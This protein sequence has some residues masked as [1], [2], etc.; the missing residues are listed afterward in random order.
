MTDQTPSVK[1]ASRSKWWKALLVASLALNLLIGG[2]VATRFFIKGPADRMVGANYTQLIPRSFFSEMPRDR[3]R[4][5]LDILK[6]YRNDFR[7]G[8]KSSDEVAAKFA[9][10][11]ADE[12]YDI[13]NVKT[14]VAEFVGQNNKLASRGGD[15]V[16]DI[17]AALTP[18]ERQIL[19]KV[20]RSRP[21]KKK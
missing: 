13:A 10:V 1:P 4:V 5:L 12:P 14:V 3:R 11:I 17:L 6:N 16:L 2:A 8:R 19:A 7:D 20:I 21:A 15:A 18:E 9:D